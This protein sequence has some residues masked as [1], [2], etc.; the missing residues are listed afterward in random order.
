MHRL[1]ST[2]QKRLWRHCYVPAFSKA[3]LINLGEKDCY[4]SFFQVFGGII[5]AVHARCLGV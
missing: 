2:E 5:P 1:S 4:S 3:G